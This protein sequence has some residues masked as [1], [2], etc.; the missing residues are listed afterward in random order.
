MK[1]SQ[2]IEFTTDRVDQFNTELDAWAARTK[3]KRIPHRATLSRDRDTPGRH[4]LIVEF[5]SYEQGRENSD[6]PETA[7]FAAFLTRLSNTPPTFRSLDVIREDD[8]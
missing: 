2:I 6:R 4:L 5:A 8:F 7:D 3:G 1:F